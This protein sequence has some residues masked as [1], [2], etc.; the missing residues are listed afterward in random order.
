MGSVQPVPDPSVEEQGHREGA[1]TF[2]G[3]QKETS[4]PAAQSGNTAPLPG[5]T[6][7]VLDLL[8]KP[9]PLLSSKGTSFKNWTPLPFPS[10]GIVLPGSSQ[11]TCPRTHRS[12]RMCLSQLLNFLT[13]GKQVWGTFA[14]SNLSSSWQPSHTQPQNIWTHFL[15]QNPPNIFQALIPLPC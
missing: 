11:D 6:D 14:I 10:K 3:S 5:V 1:E 12:L 9:S 13:A 7:S 15:S 4:S 8:A 2:K